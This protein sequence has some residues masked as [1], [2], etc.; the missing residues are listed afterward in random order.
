M[1]KISQIEIQNLMGLHQRGLDDDVIKKA[2][3]LVK[4]YPEEIILLNILFIVRNFISGSSN[5][6]CSS[7][8]QRPLFCGV[9]LLCMVFIV[10]SIIAGSI[11][12][13]KAW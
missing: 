5:F 3:V 13:N 11:G 6:Q 1:K 4:E 9:R 8:N 7:Y 10:C 2:N 12:Y